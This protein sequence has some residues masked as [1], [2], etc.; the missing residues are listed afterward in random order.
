[1]TQEDIEKMQNIPVLEERT[2]QDYRSTYNDIRD[3]LTKKPGQDKINPKID[4]DDVVFEVELLKSQEINLDY[5]LELIF[6]KNKNV[7]NKDVLV[8]DA[9]R[10]IRSSVGNRAKESLIV[11]FIHQ[12]D[13][14]NIQDKASMLEAFYAFAQAEQ[15]RE[16]EQL[17]QE[18]QLNE[19]AAKRYIATSL[20]QEYASDYGTELNSI[21]P[22][23]APL[24]PKYIT[25]KQTVFQ[26]IAA[27]VD[28]FK[29]VGGMS[30]N[31]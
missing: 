8:E 3:S 23:M 7:M 10:L 19:E 27:F 1:V 17:I 2:I 13:L 29:G 12:K 6:E 9:R 24:D 28:K 20:K 22:K 15:I 14:D 11:D 18:E 25:K 4:W 16:T 30:K 5:I 26:R 21:L 31:S